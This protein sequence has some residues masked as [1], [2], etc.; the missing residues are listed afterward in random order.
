MGVFSCIFGDRRSSR[1]VL[2]DGVPRAS[3]LV[4]PSSDPAPFIAVLSQ[5]DEHRQALPRSTGL[6]ESVLSRGMS[7]IV[8]GENAQ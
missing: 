7:I 1:G 5:A 6:L 4:R 8:A 3:T 2:D